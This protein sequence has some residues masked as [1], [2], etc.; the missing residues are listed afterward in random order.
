M[1]DGFLPV[2]KRCPCG[3]A[4]TT[5][6]HIDLINFLR[7]AE[8]QMQAEYEGP[9]FSSYCRDCKRETRLEASDIELT[10]VLGG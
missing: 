3:R 1:A 8:R 6:V 10:G 4:L 5:R 9:T 2:E 7:K